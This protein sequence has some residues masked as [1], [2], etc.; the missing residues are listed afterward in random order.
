[1]DSPWRT[2]WDPDTQLLSVWIWMKQT[3]QSFSTQCPPPPPP[4]PLPPKARSNGKQPTTLTQMKIAYF[5]ISRW[6][7]QPTWQDV[8]GIAKRRVGGRHTLKPGPTHARF[9]QKQEKLASVGGR[10]MTKG[11]NDGK[12]RAANYTCTCEG[13]KGQPRIS[14]RSIFFH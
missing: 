10:K 13:K 3:T 1:M 14:K 9:N 12:G 2:T 4:F 5:S 6:W 7:P 8:W 11:N